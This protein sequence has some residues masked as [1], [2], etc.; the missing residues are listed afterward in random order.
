MK[1]FYT[2]ILH[3][4]YLK[5]KSY[6]DKYILFTSYYDKNLLFIITNVLLTFIYIIHKR[7]NI[8]LM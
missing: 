8:L 7:L 6:Y 2:H 1:Y 4:A 5:F 3:I